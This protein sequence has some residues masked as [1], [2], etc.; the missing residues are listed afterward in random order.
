MR[1]P[2]TKPLIFAKEIVTK[3][4]KTANIRVEFDL[5]PTLATFIE[6]SAQC[7][8]AF[9][10]GDEM[11]IGFVTMVK[12]IKKLSNISSLNYLIKLELIAS[13]NNTSKFCFEAISCDEVC[14]SGEFTTYLKDKE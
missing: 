1:L 13:I 9:V 14:V 6:A 12:N 8:V 10:E 3:D 7:S 4:D 11:G 5:P 2:H